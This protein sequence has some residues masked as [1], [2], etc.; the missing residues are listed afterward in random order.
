[1]DGLFWF[2]IFGFFTFVVVIPG[3]REVRKAMS[4]S[5]A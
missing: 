1:M 5:E 4:E 3:L 2:A